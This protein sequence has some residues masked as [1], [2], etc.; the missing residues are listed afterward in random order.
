MFSLT[1]KFV[2]DDTDGQT[3][4]NIKNQNGATN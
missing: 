4:I 3:L 1:A 2:T